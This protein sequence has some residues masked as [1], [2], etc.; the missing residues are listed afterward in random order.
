MH[1]VNNERLMLMKLK[2]KNIVNMKAAWADRTNLYLLY[3][4]ALNG[5]LMCF[6]RKNCKFLVIPLIL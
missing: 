3:D 4:L 6:L 2:H 1:E 5:D